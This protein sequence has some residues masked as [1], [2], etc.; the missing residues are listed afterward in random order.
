MNS[1]SISVQLSPQLSPQFAHS[2]PLEAKGLALAAQRSASQTLLVVD[3]SPVV[4]ALVDETLRS[5][6]RIRVVN[7]GVQ[8]LALLDRDAGIDLILLDVLMPEMDGFETC[9]R[10]KAV[11]ALRDIPIIFLTSLSDNGDEAYGLT[12][13]AV[14]YIAKPVAPVTLRA[15]VNTHLELCRVRRELQQTNNLLRA[16][17]E[18][19]EG[20]IIRMR[21][22]P[23]FDERHLRWLMQPV[24]RTSGD[25]CLAAFCP[26][27]R[28]MLLV[29]DFT[30]H[31]LT[32]AIAGPGIKQAFYALC[33]QAATLQHIIASLNDLLYARLLVSQFLAAHLVEVAPERQQVRLWSGG[34]PEP[35]HVDARGE[36]QRIVASGLPLGVQAGRDVSGEVRTLPVQAGERLLFYTDGSIEAANSAGEMYEIERLQTRYSALLQSGGP[37]DELIDDVK[38]FVAG[39]EQTDDMVFLELKL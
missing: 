12:L 9:R 36:V 11:P 6:F 33:A 28:Q 29:G 2:R 25:I 16:E 8:A 27:G 15:R 30:G 32:A 18:V 14:D 23:D 5:Q 3:D 7:S 31:G 19:I 22:D 24:E 26:D 13:G 10:I 37:L 35:L 39:C 1:P 20:M 34:M 21:A 38:T 4:L 17:R